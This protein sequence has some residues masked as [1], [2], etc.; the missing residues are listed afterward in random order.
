MHLQE[1][2]SF[3]LDPKF[4]VAWKVIQYMYPLHYKCMYLQSLNMNLLRSTN[5]DEIQIQGSTLIDLWPLP[6]NQDKNRRIY[7]Q[8]DN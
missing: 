5:E 8:T 2:I 7:G 1:N 4:S 6:W 3:D